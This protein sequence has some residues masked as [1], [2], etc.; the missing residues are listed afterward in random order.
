MRGPERKV[1]SPSVAV[2]ASEEF[3]SERQPTLGRKVFVGKGNKVDAGGSVT[4]ESPWEG[5]DEPSFR[6]VLTVRLRDFN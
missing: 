3:G 2:A 6:V 5:S 1:P 4:E